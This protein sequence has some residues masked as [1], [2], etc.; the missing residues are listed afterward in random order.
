MVELLP[1]PFCGASGR[2]GRDELGMLTVEVD[3]DLVCDPEG[4]QLDTYYVEC[5]KC[6]TRGPTAVLYSDAAIKRWN[7]R[8]AANG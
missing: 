6:N 2:Y 5:I 8:E 7:K 4:K 1:C 3:F